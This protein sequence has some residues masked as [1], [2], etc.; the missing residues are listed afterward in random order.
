MRPMLNYLRKLSMPAV[1]WAVFLSPLVAQQ[2]KL[3]EHPDTIDV[4]IAGKPFT[5]YH[6]NDDFFHP[7]IRPFFWPVFASDGTEITTDQQQTDPQHGYQRSIWIGHADVNGANHWKFNATPQPKQNHI[8]FDWVRSNGFQEELVWDG[9]DGQPMLRETRT[10]KFRG[11]KDGVRAIEFKLALTPVTGDV[12]FGTHGDHGLLSVRLLEGLYGTPR[13]TSAEGTDQ[14]AVPPKPRP[15]AGQ[16]T[17][18]AETD[19]APLHTAWC[20]ESGE[21]G[22]TTYG[23]TIFDHPENPRHA[24]IW[25]AWANARLATDMFAID[26]TGPMNSGAL[27]V[28]SGTTLTVR[29]EVLVHKGT[30]SEADLKQKYAEFSVSK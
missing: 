19:P 29:Y 30:A 27:T 18:L 1:A 3:V 11:Y 22:G 7:P 6:F 9:K 24:P 12:T 5:T 23:A 16:P 17:L 14:C 26:K 4:T 2:V 21:T 10:V 20:D 15:K 28:A 25:H 8:K 13:F